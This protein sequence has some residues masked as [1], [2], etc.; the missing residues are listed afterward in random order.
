MKFNKFAVFENGQQVEVKLTQKELEDLEII[1][2]SSAKQSETKVKETKQ[3]ETSNGKPRQQ[4]I[5]EF[6]TQEE[7]SM[8]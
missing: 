1:K 6:K 4:S 7:P 8:Q 3:E 5:S 2:T